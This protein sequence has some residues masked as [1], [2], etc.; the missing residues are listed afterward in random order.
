MKTPTGWIDGESQIRDHV[1][2]L[3]G[4]NMLNVVNSAITPVQIILGSASICSFLADAAE[5]GLFLM[6][7]LFVLISFRFYLK[8]RAS[9]CEPKMTD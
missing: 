2:G 4:D 5:I 6:F 1:I 9:E 3:R 8:N 7:A